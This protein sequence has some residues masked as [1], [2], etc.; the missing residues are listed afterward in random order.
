MLAISPFCPPLEWEYEYPIDLG[1]NQAFDNLDFD[2]MFFDNINS[3]SNQDYNHQECN[4]DDVKQQSESASPQVTSSTDQQYYNDND[5][6]PILAANKKLNHNASERDRRK[7]INNMYSSLRSL[8]PD[9]GHKKKLS[10][11]VTVGKVLEYIPELQKEVKDLTHKKK[12]LASKLSAI[13]GNVGGLLIQEEKSKTEMIKETTSFSISANKLGD[14]EL[15][16]QISAFER[17]SLAEVLL[18]LEKNGFLV[19][20]VSSFQSFGGASFYNI[21]LWVS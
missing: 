12:V 9:T 10:I 8:L 4:N 6:N 21:H 20:D 11:P 15:V 16:I 18:L 17:I 7:K 2:S 3:S 14:K 19:I 13:Q 5:N 1:T